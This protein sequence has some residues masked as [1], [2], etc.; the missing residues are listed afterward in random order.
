M[1]DV[2]LYISGD[3]RSVA[4]HKEEVKASK[5]RTL[6]KSILAFPMITQTAD[7]LLDKVMI[8]TED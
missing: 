1:P 2:R 3:W 5:L 8:S 6:P 7:L 4:G